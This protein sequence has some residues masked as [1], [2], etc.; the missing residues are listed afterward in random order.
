MQ[1]EWGCRVC[2]NPDGGFWKGL[3]RFVVLLGR[4]KQWYKDVEHALEVVQKSEVS[5]SDLFDFGQ[6]T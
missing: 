4:L 3:A 5:G 2:S 1:R 6:V